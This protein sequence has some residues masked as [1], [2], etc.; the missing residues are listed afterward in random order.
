MQP[1]IAVR[2]C[3]LAA[4]FGHARGPQSIFNLG[5]DRR[6]QIGYLKAVWP[7]FVWGEFLRSGRPRGPGET[8]KKVGG[9]APHIFEGCPGP[10]GPARPQ[11]R[12]PTN[13]NK[14][15]TNPQQIPPDLKT[16]PMCHPS[17]RHPFTGHRG[18]GGP[19]EQGSSRTNKTWWSSGN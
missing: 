16:P 15:P 2:C 9:F 12:T 19:V 4:R 18:K 6:P 10:P 17:V 3:Q 11:K 8:L 14:S 5:R 13:P 1:R 7:D